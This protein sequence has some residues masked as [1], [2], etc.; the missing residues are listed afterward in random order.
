MC[1]SFQ[2]ETWLSQLRTGKISPLASIDSKAMAHLKYATANLSNILAQ[3]ML[4]RQILFF[5]AGS[6]DLTLPVFCVHSLALRA[7]PGRVEADTLVWRVAPN[8]TDGQPR[9]FQLAWSSNAG[10][11]LSGTPGSLHARSQQPMYTML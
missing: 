8:G 1:L 10:L 9:Q 7:W 2:W 11:K 3:V 6:W 4:G 5:L